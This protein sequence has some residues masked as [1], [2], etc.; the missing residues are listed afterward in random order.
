MSIPYGTRYLLITCSDPTDRQFRGIAEACSLLAKTDGVHH[1]PWDG[2]ALVLSRRRTLRWVVI[3][4]HGAERT[5]WISDGH[6][7]RL[8]PRD[9]EL[10]PG[11][12]LYLMACHQGHD[13]NR[14]RW[15][16]E[17]GGDVHGCEGE[18]ESA[19]STLFL[20]GLLDH[21]P[22]GIRRWFDRWRQANDRLRQHFPQMRSLYR[23][24][25]KDW[26]AALEEIRNAVDLGPFDDILT[27]AK[28][29]PEILSGLGVP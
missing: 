2:E 17:T 8:Y 9:L 10:P 19:L 7:R 1:L 25:G 3:S 13:A 15:V 11:V 27:V 26:S 21:G 20:L 12:D 14:Q 6:R 28:R 16:S 18:S 22:E 4:G 23:A 29:R 5:A 24:K